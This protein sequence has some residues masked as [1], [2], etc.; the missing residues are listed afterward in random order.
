MRKAVILTSLF[1]F[2]FAS[3][4][5]TEIL[6]QDN[7]VILDSLEL[8]GNGYDQSPGEEGIGLLSEDTEEM[9]GRTRVQTILL[10]ILGKEIYGPLLASTELPKVSIFT[11]DLYLVFSQS[12]RAPP[13]CSL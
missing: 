2:I 8:S 1:L 3:T 13:L 7:C 4:A 11:Q 10:S 5:G 6:T 12:L 9:E